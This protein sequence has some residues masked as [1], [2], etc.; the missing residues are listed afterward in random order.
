MKLLQYDLWP[1]SHVE[2]SH[3]A[4]QLAEMTIT[5]PESRNAMYPQKHFR[6]S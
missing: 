4:T 6:L 1:P 2:Y 5:T 3:A